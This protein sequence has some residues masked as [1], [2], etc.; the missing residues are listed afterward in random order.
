[1]NIHH[2]NIPEKYEINVKMRWT[3]NKIDASWYSAQ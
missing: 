2:K 1:M 3:T